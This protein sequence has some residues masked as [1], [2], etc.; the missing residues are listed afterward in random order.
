MTGFMT[1]PT[2]TATMKKCLIRGCGK[3]RM[4]TID[5]YLL[6]T[7][8]NIFNIWFENEILKY[9]VIRRWRKIMKLKERGCCRMLGWFASRQKV[10]KVVS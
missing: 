8:S 6:T 10:A 7:I 3:A 9:I 1:T 5:K 4:I 2:L